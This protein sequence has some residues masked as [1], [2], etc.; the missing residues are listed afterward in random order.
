MTKKSFEQSL[1]KG[2]FATCITLCTLGFLYGT[3]QS[4]AKFRSEPTS[5]STAEVEARWSALPSLTLC[6]YDIRHLADRSTDYTVAD[7]LKVFSFEMASIV[8]G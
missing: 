7:M 8:Q 2:L 3:S 1:E 4:W 5:L 6:P